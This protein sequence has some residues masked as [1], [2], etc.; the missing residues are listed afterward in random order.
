ML[1]ELFVDVQNVGLTLYNL[2]L[3]LSKTC[4][5]LI[6]FVD[7]ITTLKMSLRDGLVT[8]HRQCNREL[9][10]PRFWHPA[11]SVIS[12]DMRRVNY[13][14]SETART[15]KFSAVILQ[16]LFERVLESSWQVFRVG[17][18]WT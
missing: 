18:L 14:R 9:A 5:E 8:F 11:V 13:T 10:D 16:F 7:F 4:A 17:H 1:L 2:S 12:G 3:N 15:R 6:C